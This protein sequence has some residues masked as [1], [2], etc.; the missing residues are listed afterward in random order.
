MGQHDDAILIFLIEISKLM[1]SFCFL[2]FEF[3]VL[4]DKPS[5]S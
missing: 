1:E 3:V 5:T 2:S 4:K